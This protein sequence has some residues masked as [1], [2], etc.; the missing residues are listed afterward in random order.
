MIILKFNEFIFEKAVPL[1]ELILPEPKVGLIVKKKKNFGIP[2]ATLILYNFND[3][4]ILGYISMAK[5]SSNSDVY[6]V[7]RI[8]SEKNYGPDMY[9][10]AMMSVYPDGV[11]PSWT[12]KPAALN[13]W[14]YYNEQRTDVNK[15]DIWKGS[16]D[17]IDHYQYNVED[18][19]ETNPEILSLINTR[20]SLKP[21]AE[22]NIL[23]NNALKYIKEFRVK[24]D[25]FSE[26]ELDRYFQSKYYT[27]V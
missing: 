3:N 4:R 12:I 11:R 22:F 6:R 21:T 16:D 14:K 2:Q 24:S 5:L 27:G 20:Y 25:V 17:Y 1:D 18:E 19:E 10:L 23:L 8:A 15:K 13:I 9:D 7:D 26:K